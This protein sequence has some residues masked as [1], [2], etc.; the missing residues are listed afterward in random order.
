MPKSSPPNSLREGGWG[1]R[2]T[3]V[4][5]YSRYLDTLSC[6][7]VSQLALVTTEVGRNSYYRGDGE[8]GATTPGIEPGGF[9][10][11]L[12]ARGWTDSNKP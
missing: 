7:P 10:D 11:P 2:K 4:G 3:R 6:R 5:F 8:G 1:V 12:G 9:P